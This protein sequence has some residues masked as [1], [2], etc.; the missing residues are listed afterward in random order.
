MEVKYAA[1]C[2]DEHPSRFFFFAFL[3][4]L[5]F[6][7]LQQPKLSALVNVSKMASSDLHIYFTIK[8]CKLSF[9]CSDFICKV[10]V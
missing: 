4:K 7:Y 2:V 5:L 1:L 3:I 10:L 6:I 8:H 9:V